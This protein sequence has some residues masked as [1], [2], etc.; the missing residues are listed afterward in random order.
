VK[1]PTPEEAMHADECEDELRESHLCFL[2]QWKEE[3]RTRLQ[4]QFSQRRAPISV[5]LAFPTSLFAYHPGAPKLSL[6]QLKDEDRSIFGLSHN[7][8]NI[9]PMYKRYKKC[10]R[11]IKINK[12]LYQPSNSSIID[13]QKI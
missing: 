11:V 9:K 6:Q 3:R 4:A 5:K 8:A 10:D 7:N 2:A 13:P 12:N 1:F